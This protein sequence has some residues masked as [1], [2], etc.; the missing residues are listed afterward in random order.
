MMRQIS[1]KIWIPVIALLVIA[2]VLTVFFTL[3]REEK[4]PEIVS[5]K[6]TPEEK[7]A[8]PEIPA[9][10]KTYRNEEY[11]FEVKYPEEQISSIIEGPVPGMFLL[12]PD[13]GNPVDQMIQLAVGNS[14]EEISGPPENIEEWKITKIYV[15]NQEV[16]RYE[17]EGEVKEMRG[18]EG[19]FRYKE[20]RVCCLEHKGKFYSF[21]F[22]YSS[23]YPELF[24][25]F[26]QILK[27][28]RLID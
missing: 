25:L 24:T 4:A 3:P 6:V 19:P 1:P 22:L 12:D 10:W 2:V 27:S 14:L 9:D 5:P 28:F 26:D 20:V 23:E 7:V 15:V 8:Q 21:R 13:R 18:I 16:T 11:G 17:I